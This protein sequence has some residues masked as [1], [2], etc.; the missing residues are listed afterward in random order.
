MIEDN[1]T[2]VKTDVAVGQ[3]QIVDGA[4]REFRL[5]KVFQVVAPAAERAAER[6]GRINFI[7][8]FVARHE[9]IKQMP[10]I[11]E[12]RLADGRFQMGNVDF[13]ARAE[14]AKSE[15]R[16]RRDKRVTR[17][18]RIKLRGAQQYQ[19]RAG[20]CVPQLLDECL[21]RVRGRDFM[22]QRAH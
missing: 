8:Q 14:A 16:I 2:I 11:A 18:W 17:G 9:R 19:P 20:T 21:G 1:Q 5:G 13:A 22:N 15:K 10:R 3:F 4:A 12:L 6:K 7:E